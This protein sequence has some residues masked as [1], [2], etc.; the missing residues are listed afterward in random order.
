V[1][2]SA[3]EAVANGI[4]MGGKDVVFSKPVVFYVENFLDFP[5]GGIVPV[6][7]Y[8]NDRAAW[9][10]HDNGRII[11]ILSVTGGLADVDI[12]GDGAASDAASLAALGITD[13]ER[14]KLA[15]LYAAGQ[16]LWRVTLPHLSTWDCNWGWW[17][18]D[19]AEW[20][21][22]PQRDV[23]AG[24]DSTRPPQ[25]CDAS[26]FSVIGIQSQTLGESVGLAGT[27]FRLHYASGRAPG[28]EG[29][30]TLN[31][32]VSR[33]TLP[34]SL[35][36]IALELRV[37]GQVFRKTL[38]ALTNQIYHF[39][40]DGRDAYGRRVQGQQTAAIRIGYVY[41]AFYQQPAAVA[42]SFGYRA[43]GPPFVHKPAREDYILWQELK[44]TLANWD[45]RAQSLGG[46]TL[47]AHHAYLP[48]QRLLYP[49][50]GGP[51]RTIEDFIDTAAGGGQ[52][53]AEGVPA[54][55]AYV[56]HPYG[57]AFAPDGSY[58]IAENGYARVRR[59]ARDGLIT[60]VA[61]TGG[62]YCV[63]VGPDGSLFI[64]EGDRVRRVTPDGIVHTVAGIA[65]QQGFNGESGLAT[66]M[67]LA[68]ACLLYTSRCV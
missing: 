5:V 51:P 30:Y 41:E 40:W 15:N 65:G 12:D 25:E 21:R 28:R 13:A 44:T 46:W 37:A 10:P 18:P 63:A 31:I 14:A 64:T 24:Q 8:D 6:G 55:S 39:V 52:S 2:L 4:K 43:G 36:R 23:D 22:V 32:P 19:D 57:I 35:K 67:L 9:V 7:Y 56:Y 42:R 16:S 60:T 48:A 29:A 45:A 38:P 61:G 58:Y 3:D 17:P 47:D 20:P 49:G 33:E 54:T 11:Q 1:E 34:A 50:D 27:P 59:V 66:Q 53:S 62:A 68:L 26:G